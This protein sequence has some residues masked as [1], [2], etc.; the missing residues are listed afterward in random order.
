MFSCSSKVTIKTYRIAKRINYAK[1]VLSQRGS[2]PAAVTISF[3]ATMPK[4]AH[5]IQIETFSNLVLY[6]NINQLILIVHSIIIFLS[7][8]IYVLFDKF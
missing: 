2:S 7:R 3:R 6:I 5:K 1:Q 4:Y 8:L